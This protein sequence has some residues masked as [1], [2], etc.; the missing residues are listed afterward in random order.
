MTDFIWPTPPTALDR[1]RR[2][3]A[4]ALLARLVSPGHLS[5]IG[6]WSRAPNTAT[7][8]HRLLESSQGGEAW[9]GEYRVSFEPESARVALAMYQR[10]G[11]AVG[12]AMPTRHVGHNPQEL[13]RIA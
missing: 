1:A 2:Q 10:L 6:Q 9:V 8:T 7:W 3:T 5:P 12:G 13:A 4:E 11:R